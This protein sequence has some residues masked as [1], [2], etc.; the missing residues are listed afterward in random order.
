MAALSGLLAGLL[1]IALTVS[2]ILPYIVS[3]HKIGLLMAKSDVMS[4]RTADLTNDYL[5][6]KGYNFLTSDDR[7]ANHMVVLDGK[8]G[9]Q[10]NIY[11]GAEQ[12]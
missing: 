5:Y 7:K 6:Q 4:G 12:F 2:G 1:I 9:Q 8:V 3:N 11:T 10:N